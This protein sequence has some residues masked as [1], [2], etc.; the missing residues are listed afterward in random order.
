MLGEFSEHKSRLA[1]FQNGIYLFGRL[2]SPEPQEAE[3]KASLCLFY[4]P[5]AAPPFWSCCE[6][7]KSYCKD[8]VG[9]FAKMSFRSASCPGKSPWISL[10]L[11]KKK[12]ISAL[13]LFKRLIWG[14]LK[15]QSHQTSSLFSLKF[16]QLCR[17]VA[18]S[19]YLWTSQALWALDLISFHPCQ[20]LASSEEPEGLVKYHCLTLG[21]Q[22][23]S[24]RKLRKN[25]PQG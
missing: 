19:C 10:P 9:A 2:G 17:N 6:N 24:P 20:W 8:S 1:C 15:G 13:H 12:K 5:L 21:C 4:F 25:C 22:S 3:G 18:P 14:Q 7:V 16:F 11:K 23:E